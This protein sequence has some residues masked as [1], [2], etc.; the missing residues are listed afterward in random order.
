MSKTSSENLSK[1]PTI[2][3]AI[4]KGRKILLD[5][6]S[7]LDFNCDQYQNFT[8]SDIY[9]MTKFNCLDMLVS[10]RIGDETFKCYVKYQNDPA[11]ALKGPEVDVVTED[12]FYTEYSDLEQNNF[13]TT[14]QDKIVNHQ[15]DLTTKGNLL[16]CA[17]SQNS[18]LQKK[19]ILVFILYSEPNAALITKLKNLY[20]KDGIFVVPMN[21][22][23]L[24][25]NIQDHFLVPKH[26]ILTVENTQKMVEKLGFEDNSINTLTN[27]LPEISR[28]DPV[29]I[30]ILM[31][32]GQVCRIERSS[33]TAVNSEY[34][35]VCI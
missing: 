32:P 35:R 34:F 11:K 19:D 18:V 29:A 8:A 5:Q 10:K 20:D 24:Q 33:N 30:S 4:F 23:R 21:I 1:M 7:N 2:V 16:E 12:L 6:L 28:F 17:V 15:D 13:E 27:G 22:N 31:R 3:A 26:T 9:A 25:F 14:Y